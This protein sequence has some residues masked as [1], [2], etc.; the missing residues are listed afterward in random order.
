MAGEM[1]EREAQDSWQKKGG[2]DLVGLEAGIE[3]VPLPPKG[4]R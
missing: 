3:M 4:D 1:V 2:E